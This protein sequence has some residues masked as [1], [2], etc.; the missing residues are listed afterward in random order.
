MI[1]LCL[2][3]YVYYQRATLLIA[4]MAIVLIGLLVWAITQHHRRS[5]LIRE[6]Q[7]M[8]DVSHYDVEFDMVVK[9]MHLCTWRIDVANKIFKV[10]ADYTKSPEL[11]STFSGIP[12]SSMFDQMASWDKVRMTIAIN[13]L[14]GGIT[15]EYHEVYERVLPPTGLRVWEE[16]FATVAERNADGT[17]K[18][19][20]G[21]TMDIDNQKKI[22]KA[23]IDARNKAEESDRLKTD[24]LNNISHEIRTP[25]NAIVGFTDIISHVEGEERTQMAKLIR[26]NADILLRIF[27]DMVKMANMES[28]TDESVHTENFSVNQM[29]RDIVDEYSRKNTNPDLRIY[30][31][32]LPK[33]VYFGTDRKKLSLIVEHF[34]SNAVKFT[35]RG[36]IEVIIEQDSP[37]HLKI[38]VRDTGKGISPEKTQHI[39]DRFVKLD[40]FTQG[41]GLG[42]SVC[43][44]YAQSLG[45]Q[46]GV[47]SEVGKGSTFWIEL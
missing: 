38:S 41:T 30:K 22:E 26:D 1:Y 19:I 35:N 45:G 27:D 36:E 40:T 2:F 37:L 12:V 15:D 9:A 3:L 29:V 20:V 47:E 17:P 4:T 46:I 7:A 31:R 18:T 42:L 34:V 6:L 25:L 23:L 14:C 10:E 28:K 8:G 32:K 24:F 33:E 39:F 16:S 44:S 5:V 43:R 11:N 13:N 21:A